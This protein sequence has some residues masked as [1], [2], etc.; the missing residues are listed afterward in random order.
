MGGSE[1]RSAFAERSAALVARLRGRQSEIE[2]RLHD[3]LATIADPLEAPDPGY[4][5]DLQGAVSVALDYA[6]DAIAKGEGGA[7][8]PPSE[9]LEQA[10]RA[11]RN[12]V[13]LDVVLRRYLAGFA[14]VTQS[15]REE[16]AMEERL[17]GLGAE[18]APGLAVV[19]DRLLE[20]VSREHREEAA[21]C[22]RSSGWWLR[23]RFRRLLAGEAID[24]AGVP[25]EF[26]AVH[27]AVLTV[28]GPPCEAEIRRLAA[29]LDCQALVVE[30][31][32]STTWCWFG[33]RG[34]LEPGE[35]AG[36]LVRLGDTR[37]V[38]M[39]EP[40]DGLHGWRLSHRQAVAV[41]PIA[42]RARPRVC[43]YGDFSLVASALQDRLLIDSLTRLYLE[44]LTRAKGAGGSLRGTLRAY[45][46]A[47]RNVSSAAA[48]LGISRKTIANHLR[49]VESALERPIGQVAAE[50]DLALRTEP[51]LSVHTAVPT[52]GSRFVAGS[53]IDPAAVSLARPG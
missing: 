16:E 8:P 38:G 44:P 21:L 10:R 7:F 46:A 32:E 11:A 26:D 19:L 33:R 51:F 37:A 9:L 6:L 40:G 41:M 50:L 13:D 30:A 20:A 2:A 5:D 29:E 36:S 49:L 12:G 27:V 18:A 17:R 35:L 3:R 43:R 31:P 23:E 45:F 47:D 4:S 14:V 1:G 39:G 25:Y 34:A 15:L 24:T 28:G 53:H 52:K 42:V 48:A 22:H